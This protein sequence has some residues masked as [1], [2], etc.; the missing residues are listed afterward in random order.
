MQNPLYPDSEIERIYQLG[1][2]HKMQ[3][4]Q[5]EWLEFLS[6]LNKRE[7]M[8]NVLE[9][10]CYE[11]GTSITMS[12]FTDKITCVDVINPPM[13]DSTDF[14]K[15]CNFNYMALNSQ[16]PESIK[17]LLD[18]VGELDLLFIDGDH[19]YEGALRDYQNY[20]PLVKKGGLIAFHDIV[21]SHHHRILGCT[22]YKAWEQIKVNHEWWDEIITDNFGKEHTSTE[23]SAVSDAWGGIG[24]VIK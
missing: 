2:S 5:W 19:S 10:G 24:V 23:I 14:S 9:I 15:S 21:N 3:Q 18:T 7:R 20:S 12:Y 6:I 16:K 8:K 4:K 13:F 22:V 11:G 1:R 17:T